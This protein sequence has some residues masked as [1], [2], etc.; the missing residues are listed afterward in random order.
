MSPSTHDGPCAVRLQFPLII[1]IPLAVPN[2]VE[3]L[4]YAD[5]PHRFCLH[6][7]DFVTFFSL[8]FSF[9]PAPWLR[10]LIWLSLPFLLSV[11]TQ[12]RA[13]TNSDSTFIQYGKYSLLLAYPPF[14][15]LC[16][17]LCIVSIVWVFFFSW[18]S[19]LSSVLTTKQTP[20]TKKK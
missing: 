7:Y 5:T 14:L 15:S 9:F 17:F 18:P 20:E 6:L 4:Q 19:L 12:I 16:I 1:P 8:F 11:V 3:T 2:L 10:S 13:F